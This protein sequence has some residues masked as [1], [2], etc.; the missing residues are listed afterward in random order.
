MFPQVYEYY[1]WL[2]MGTGEVSLVKLLGRF[3]NAHGSPGIPPVMTSVLRRGERGHVHIL[4]M[5]SYCGFDFDCFHF[6]QLTRDS[7]SP[8]VLRC[9]WE[10]WS[11]PWPSP[12]ASLGFRHLPLVPFPLHFFPKELHFSLVLLLETWVPVISQMCQWAHWHCRTEFLSPP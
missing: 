7:C 5:F 1:L 4:L 6:F 9:S 12:S 11:S 3:V 2:A 8:A 10:T